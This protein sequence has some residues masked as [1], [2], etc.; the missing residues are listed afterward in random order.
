MAAKSSSRGYEV[1]FVN[2]VPKEIETSCPIC[3]DVVLD[4]KLAICCGHSFCATCIGNWEE[5]GK[6]CPLC[7]KQV[8]VVDDKRLER[9]LNGYEVYCPNKDKGCK[10][11]GKLGQLEDHL[12]RHNSIFDEVLKGCQFQEVQ[13]GTC[14]SY[15]CERQFMSH[16]ISNECLSHEVECEYRYVG[17]EFKKPRRELRAHTKDCVNVHLSLVAKYMKSSLSHKER[18]IEQLRDELRQQRE[19]NAVHVQE[20]KQQCDQLSQTTQQK[21]RE[22]KKLTQTIKRQHKF[23]LNQHW[24]LLMLVFLVVAIIDAYVYQRTQSSD[25]FDNFKKQI[26]GIVS[27]SMSVK[28]KIEEVRKQVEVIQNTSKMASVIEVEDLRKQVDVMHNTSRIFSDIIE[29]KFDYVRSQVDINMHNTSRMSIKHEDLKKQ[30]DALQDTLTMSSQMI[31][32]KFEEVRK[33]IAEIQKTAESSKSYVGEKEFQEFQRMRREIQLLGEQV[34]FP[35]LPVYLKLMHMTEHRKH[36]SPWLSMPFYTHHKGYKLRLVVYL[37]GTKGGSKTHISVAVYLMSGR[38]DEHLK[39]PLNITFTVTLLHVNN[40]TDHISKIFELSSRRYNNNVIGRVWNGTMAGNGALKSMFAPH[41]H[42]DLYT[43]SDTI[44]F[45]VG[46]EAG[47]PKS[48]YK[49]W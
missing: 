10:W 27:T 28:T 4:P 32:E 26:E 14:Q 46:T 47:D 16:H 12:N 33:Q 1:N 3:L 35:V 17:C 22:L 2:E 34:D 19:E 7:N 21:C 45:R 42:L 24:I 40:I 29:G 49:F 39:W 37:N 44:K 25:A 23:V 18:E 20:L 30:V 11:T 9:I 41:D 13:C 38:Y 48:W 15:Q 6:P 36:G 8:K 43:K 31:D 5:K